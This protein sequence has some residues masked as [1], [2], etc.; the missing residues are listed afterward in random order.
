M[1]KILLV[2]ALL[3][4]L[5]NWMYFKLKSGESKWFSYDLNKDATFIGEYSML[6]YIPNIESTNDGVKVNLYEPNSS[7]YYTKVFQKQDSQIYTVRTPGVHKVCFEGTKY[8]FQATDSVRVAIK[9]RDDLKHD[10][11]V[12]KVLKTDDI[13]E[14]K[15]SMDKLRSTAVKIIDTL[16]RGEYKL[17]DFEDLKNQYISR[18]AW[19]Y[20]ITVLIVIWCGAFEAYL[21]RAAMLKGASK[22]K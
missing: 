8:L 10:K 1:S 3:V 13:K 15:Q 22:L 21:F 19:S 20:I 14:A 4:V 6:D 9:M 5:S 11:T 18:M 7:S 2:T 16:E 17:K 12:S